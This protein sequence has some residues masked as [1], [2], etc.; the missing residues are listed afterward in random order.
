MISFKREDQQSIK[1][2]KKKAAS[3]GVKKIIEEHFSKTSSVFNSSSDRA[4]CGYKEI[5]NFLGISTRS[6]QRYLHLF[7]ISQLGKRKHIL[8]LESDLKK[9]FRKNYKITFSKKK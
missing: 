4:L 5:S 8:V 1:T 7:P 3:D 6:L 9:W 2:A